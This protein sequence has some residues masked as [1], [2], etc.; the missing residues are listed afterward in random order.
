MQVLLGTYV[1]MF[2][3]RVKIALAEKGIK[4]E[5]KEENLM[6]KSPLLLLMNP[7]HKS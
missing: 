2:A 3:M 1:S 6:N 5:Y 4:Y 7:I